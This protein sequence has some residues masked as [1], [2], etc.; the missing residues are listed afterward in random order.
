[1]GDQ[2]QVSIVTK[3]LYQKLGASVQAPASVPQGSPFTAIVASGPASL[4]KLQATGT[5]LGDATVNYGNSILAVVPV[6]NGMTF[7]SAALIGGDTIT[8]G[9]AVVTYCPTL[10]SPGCT[11]QTSAHYSNTTAPYVQVSLPGVTIPGGGTA[12]VPS[13]VVTMTASGAA[14]TQSQTHLTEFSLNTSTSLGSAFFHGYPSDPAE[15]DTDPPTFP[16]VDLNTTAIT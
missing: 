16:A 12:T 7:V 4:P 1:M 3:N 13:A 15:P 9:K 2:V 5:F 8:S 10:T 14:G 6:P 11:A